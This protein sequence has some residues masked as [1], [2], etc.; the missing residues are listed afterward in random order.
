MNAATFSG[1]GQWLITG[2][3]DETVRLWSLG[4]TGPQAIPV[5][6][7][8]DQGPIGIIAVSPDGHWL[9][10][11]GEDKTARLHN[12]RLTEWVTLAFKGDAEGTSPPLK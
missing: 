6:L 2:T 12:L 3:G 1:D 9:I 10:T 4:Q 11:S 7:R 5:V 8:P